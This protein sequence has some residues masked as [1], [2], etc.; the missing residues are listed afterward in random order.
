M[1]EVRSRAVT[2]YF[3]PV[4]PWAWVTSRWLVAAAGERD[5]TITWR[6]FSLLM[7]NGEN[8]PTEHRPKLEGSHRALRVVVALGRNVNQEAVGAFYTEL[9]H[10]HFTDGQETP[11]PAATLD[12]AGLDPDL[13]PAATDE[14]LDANITAAMDDAHR[15]AGS[16]SGSPILAVA[17]ADRGF[18]GPVLTAVPEG[19]DVGRLWDYVAGLSAIASFHELK[20]DRDDGPTFP[21]R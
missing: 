2:F 11:D 1:P 10:R 7:H 5:L 19:D 6:P 14:A 16:G 12:A 4:C 20:R 21:A 15:L 17:G 9:G 8:I 3:D 18:F 13:A